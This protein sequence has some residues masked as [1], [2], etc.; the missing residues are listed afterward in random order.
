MFTPLRTRLIS[1]LALLTLS[2][3][4]LAQP[5]TSADIAGSAANDTRKAV[6]VEA[7]KA[8]DHVGQQRYALVIGINDYADAKIPD[9]TL[10]EKDAKAI[11]D[12]LTSS[13]TGGID[14]ANTTQGNR[15]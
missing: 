11:Y 9:L 6:G 15:M 3:T 5:A 10:C 2:A 13:Q 1:L 4:A 8:I 12:V 7:I 14:K